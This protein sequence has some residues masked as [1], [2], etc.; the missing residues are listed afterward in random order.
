MKFIH[1]NRHHSDCAIVAT[2]N[3]LKW[4]GKE[5][6]YYHLDKI[7][8]QFRYR[9]NVGMRRNSIAPFW[10]LIHAPV[11]SLQPGTTLRQ[12]LEILQTGQALVL[13]YKHKDAVTAH[14]AMA[15]PR[16][17]GK[18]KLVNAGRIFPN[19]DSILRGFIDKTIAMDV[20]IVR[21]KYHYYDDFKTEKNR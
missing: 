13:W 20:W 17:N 6:P 10:K 1:K 15:V 12:A 16:K 3:L 19:W 18:I 8:K 4:S 5:I 7:A 11:K 14:I 2:Y 9:R 21:G